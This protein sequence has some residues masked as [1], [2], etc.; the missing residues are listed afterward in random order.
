[1]RTLVISDLHL[2][3]WAGHDVLRR[4]VP[5][6]RLLEALDGIDRL[7]LLGDVLELVS[8]HPARA[9]AIAEPVVREIGRRLGPDREA[10]V[11]PGNHD[12]ALVRAWALAQGSRLTPATTVDPNASAILA[13]LVSWLAPARTR[14]SYPGVWLADG[15][16][17][18]HGH[19]LDR[20]LIPEST[21]GLPRPHTRSARAWKERV[22]TISYESSRGRR[23]RGSPD[24]FAGRLMARP[25]GALLESAAEAMRRLTLPQLPWLLMNA[26]LTPVT[27]AVL[28]RQMRFAT[29]PAVE[30]VARRL[31]VEADWIVFG[32]VHRR[33]PLDG[34]WWPPGPGGVR[35]VN[36]G[37]WLYEPLLIDRVRPPHP[38]WPGGAVLLEPGREPCTIGLLD[39]LTPAQL[40]GT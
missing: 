1:M 7:V 13:R 30:L 3:S 11:V 26:G 10:I 32:H 14:V 24:T 12:A 33:G 37:A 27:A 25:V 2:G 20:H 23:R 8:R 39:D 31:G 35:V 40:T 15:V 16:W 4:P 36:P 28:D 38:Y 18:T 34:E 17:A 5:R 9:I 22:A 6:A 19:Y 21:M 29:I